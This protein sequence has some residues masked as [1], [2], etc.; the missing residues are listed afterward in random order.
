MNIRRILAYFL[1]SVLLVLGDAQKSSEPASLK[2]PKNPKTATSSKTA[3][4]QAKQARPKANTPDGTTSGSTVHRSRN[5]CDG[6]KETW[7][8]TTLT[9]VH[10]KGTPGRYFNKMERP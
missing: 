4:I 1:F 10:F 7:L 8:G 5:M 9:R 3:E 2:S 6:E